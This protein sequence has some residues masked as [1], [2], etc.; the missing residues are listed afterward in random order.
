MFVFPA[1]LVV[2]AS[3]V[4][5]FT[6]LISTGYA[7]AS[8]RHRRSASRSPN[9]GPPTGNRE[10]PTRKVLESLKAPRSWFNIA[11]DT[12]VGT[13]DD[14]YFSTKE[15]TSPSSKESVVVLGSVSGLSTQ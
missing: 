6:P 7:S 15:A 13:V 1:L 4:T 8:L 14:W 10:A 3:S 5:C 9:E 11:A 12:A 2:F